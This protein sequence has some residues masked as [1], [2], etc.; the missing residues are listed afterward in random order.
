MC[1]CR[2]SKSRSVR[3]RCVPIRR[4]SQTPHQGGYRNSRPNDYSSHP[5]R[6][7][8]CWYQGA[9]QK[10]QRLGGF[11]ILVDVGFKKK[12]RHLVLTQCEHRPAGLVPEFA[13]GD[14]S[15]PHALKRGQG[16][17]MAPQPVKDGTDIEQSPAIFAVG[18][19]RIVEQFERTEQIIR[20]HRR[21]AVSD[22]IFGLGR[23]LSAGSAQ[24]QTHSED[25]S[26]GP[27]RTRSYKLH[28][29]PGILPSTQTTT[30]VNCNRGK[31]PGAQVSARCRIRSGKGGI[32]GA[33]GTLRRLPR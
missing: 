27:G 19:G 16:D 1:S 7:T 20:L 30:L 5:F 29:P 33:S 18:R 22:Q 9:A 31:S 3:L 10:F 23:R 32:E 2:G 11:R 17:P 8:R 28:Y 13:M 6:R 12:G 21:E 14:F 24:N 15:V 25:A 4:L 26:H